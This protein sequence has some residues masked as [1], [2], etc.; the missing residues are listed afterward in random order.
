MIASAV[1]R[2]GASCDSSVARAMTRSAMSLQHG[3]LDRGLVEE[4]G[5]Q[6]GETLRHRRLLRARREGGEGRRRRRRGGANQAR[7][8]SGSATANDGVLPGPVGETQPVRPVADRQEPGE[9]RRLGLDPLELLAGDRPGLRAPGRG[10]EPD[11]AAG[12]HQRPGPPAPVRSGSGPAR[13]PPASRRPTGG[14]STTRGRTPGLS[15]RFSSGARTSRT[16]S[17]PRQGGRRRPG[18]APPSAARRVAQG[19]SRKSS[20]RRPGRRIGRWRMCCQTIHSKARKI[21]EERPP[22]DPAGVDL[23]RLA[24]WRHGAIGPSPGSAPAPPDG[25]TPWFARPGRLACNSRRAAGWAGGPACR[26]RLILQ[27]RSRGGKWTDAA[28]QGD[29]ER[30]EGRPGLRDRPVD[31]P[32]ADR[33]RRRARR[34]RRALAGPGACRADHEG[35]RAGDDGRPPLRD[36]PF[37]PP[38]ADRLR[39]A[40]CARSRPAPAG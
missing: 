22:E 17:D 2:Y 11:P 12:Q 15:H 40:S 13:S 10:Q 27:D 8:A 18:S 31:Q 38:A 36:G 29:A 3:R 14:T 30:G 16:N 34:F 1:G 26:A 9:G 33:D 19:A 23:E 39:L 7:T 35:H 20:N 32:Q 5:D 4:V 21:S 6:H 25:Q 28:N 37:R 24:G